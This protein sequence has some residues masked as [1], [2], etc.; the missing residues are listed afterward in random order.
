MQHKDVNCKETE[1]SLHEED[2]TKLKTN[3]VMSISLGSFKLEVKPA[4]LNSIAFGLQ[5]TPNIAQ[6]C[7]MKFRV[8]L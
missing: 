1:I 2:T 6:C 7:E 4:F 3:N 8:I 5:F